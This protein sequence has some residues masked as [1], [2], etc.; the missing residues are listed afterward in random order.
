MPALIIIWSF[1]KNNWQLVLAGLAIMAL[2]GYIEMLRLESKHYKT[3]YE[4]VSAELASAEKR[5]EML[6]SS[7]NGISKKYQ[8]LEKE[9]K[10]YAE[11]N[12]KLYQDNIQKDVELNTLRV[13]YAAVGLF[14]QSKRNP[15]SPA[16]KANA[17]DAGKT[18]SSASSGTA[19]GVQRSIPLAE[20]FSLVA[21]NDANH[22][23]CYDQVLTWQSFWSDYEGAVTRAGASETGKGK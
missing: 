15:S 19:G 21:K 7:V 9:K 17:K 3:K 8:D 4:E 14:N 12:I 23:K 13:S 22:W 11:A 2:V 6:L 10:D 16:P 5:E 20:I 1:V 18:D